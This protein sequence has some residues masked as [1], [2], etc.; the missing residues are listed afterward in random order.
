MKKTAEINDYDYKKMIKDF[1]T[2][3]RFENHFKKLRKK[4]EEEGKKYQT[5]I[6]HMKE[7][8]EE[9]YKKKNKDLVNRLNQKESL[10][11]TSL[12][13]KHK[14]K[15]KE[16]E[17][18]IAQLIEKEKI[19]KENVEKYMEEQEKLRLIFEEETHQKRILYIL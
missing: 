17:R 2:T 13:N 7:Y 4:W 14:D 5:S 8:R 1:E 18:A 16:K 12:E 3:Q 6:E 15:T 9:T 11:I 19:A 10:L